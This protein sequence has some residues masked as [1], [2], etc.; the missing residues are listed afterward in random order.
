MVM[1]TEV[2]ERARDPLFFRDLSKEL[3][4]LKHNDWTDWE[5]E[6][7]GQMARK[8]DKYKHSDAERAKLAQIY[9]FS[10]LKSSYEGHTV[11]EMVRV[12]HNYLADLSENDEEF[13]V[14]LFER[15]PKSIRIR[16]MWRVIR[17]ARFCRMYLPHAA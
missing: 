15:E 3:F 1:M 17:L 8:S 4:L 6:W 2:A 10:R 9:S 11:M 16:E 5:L 12:G 14:G 13:I 7:L